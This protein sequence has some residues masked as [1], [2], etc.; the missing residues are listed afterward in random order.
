MLPSR[1]DF[2]EVIDKLLA[3]NHVRLQHLEFLLLHNFT[4]PKK[5]QVLPNAGM[6]IGKCKTSSIKLG[7]L[8]QRFE[9]SF[10]FI[11]ALIQHGTQPCPNSI[12][13]AIC[14]N[15]YRL[16]HYLTKTYSGPKNSNFAFL[17]A[18]ILISK[19]DK[20]DLELFQTILKKGCIAL[21]INPKVQPPLLCAIDKERYDI[22]AVLI[23]CGAN[24]L[25]MQFAK[26]TTVVHEAT[27]IALHTG[28]YANYGFLF[29][30]GLFL[31]SLYNYMRMCMY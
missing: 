23:E 4:L 15:D 3:H 31:W 27:K 22:A 13:Y 1:S 24:L 9:L 16:F 30:R 14:H 2:T 29:V 17:D 28:M 19:F 6:A 5:K 11:K 25:E 8:L 20:I 12:E 10:S 26:Y 21:G 18:S 7:S